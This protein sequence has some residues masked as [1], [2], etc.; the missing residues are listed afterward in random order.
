MQYGLKFERYPSVEQS[1]REPS[2]CGVAVSEYVELFDWESVGYIA[3]DLINFLTR[4]MDR[5]LS[6]A[7]VL[8]FAFKY[9]FNQYISSSL[10][11]IVTS[12]QAQPEIMQ[13]YI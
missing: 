2:R 1:S 6:S 13:W 10:S 8:F 9:I 4:L 5:V 3:G 7:D 12:C 11:L